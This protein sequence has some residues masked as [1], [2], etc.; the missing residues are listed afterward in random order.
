[1]G[2]I[3]RQLTRAGCQFPDRSQQLLHGSTVLGRTLNGRRR[4]GDLARF[5]TL[6][7]HVDLAKAFLEPLIVACG[8]PNPSELSSHAALSSA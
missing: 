3:V 5:P 4:S 8:P 6:R 2:L 7:G 1:M